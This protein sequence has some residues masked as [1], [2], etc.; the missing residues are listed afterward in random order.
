MKITSN[1]KIETPY[2]EVLDIH[3]EFDPSNS[4]EEGYAALVGTL[5]DLINRNKLLAEALN[6]A[7]ED[8]AAPDPGANV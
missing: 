2:R 1:Q 8:L 3:I 4:I 6:R 7:E 5:V